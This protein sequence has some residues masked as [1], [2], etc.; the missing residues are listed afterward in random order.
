[1]ATPN[2]TIAGNIF[3]VNNKSGLAFEKIGGIIMLPIQPAE[4]FVNKPDKTSRPDE[5]NNSF[6]RIILFYHFGGF[7]VGYYLN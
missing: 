6:I 5:F 1:M 4:R 7:A 3:V 2:E